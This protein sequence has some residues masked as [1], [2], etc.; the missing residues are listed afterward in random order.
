[1]RVPPSVEE[2]QVTGLGA[3]DRARAVDLFHA[4]GFA[5]VRDYQLAARTRAVISE[6]EQR[7]EPVRVDVTLEPHFRS[8]LDV[9]DNTVTFVPSGPDRMHSSDALRQIKKTA[10]IQFGK[11]GK[12]ALNLIGMQPTSWDPIDAGCFPRYD[13]STREVTKIGLDGRFPYVGLPLRRKHSTY[14]ECRPPERGQHYT[15]LPKALTKS[16]V[17][18]YPLP[19]SRHEV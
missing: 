10:A 2:D 7:S 11:P 8:M 4:R 12:A 9:K 6:E 13:R 3:Q 1:M 17:R 18:D 14:V 5:V 16:L 19:I 15:V